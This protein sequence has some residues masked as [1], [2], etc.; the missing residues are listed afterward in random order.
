MCVGLL[1]PAL[2]PAHREK[3]EMF[4]EVRESYMSEWAR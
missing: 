2:T 4:G 3:T 1:T